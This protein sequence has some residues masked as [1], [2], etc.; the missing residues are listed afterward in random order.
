MKIIGSSKLVASMSFA[1]LMVASSA[2]IASAQNAKLDDVNGLWTATLDG[3]SV[4]GD[5][6]TESYP[7]AGITLRFQGKAVALT[8]NGNTL[9][10][11][12]GGGSTTGAVGV[13][14]GHNSASASA[15]TDV[16]LTMTGFATPDTTPEKDSM[17]GTWFGH[18][19]TLARDVS[20]K[21]PIDA[22]LPGD[23]PWVRYLRDVLIPLSAQD[24][25]STHKFDKTKGA[26]WLKSTELGAAD[27]WVHK[28]YFK[29]D[30]S[31]TAAINGMDGVLYTPRDI[32]ATKFNQI[33]QAN[34]S[35]AQKSSIALVLSSLSLYFSTACGG[36]VRIH[37]T[38][39]SDSVIYYITDRRATATIGLCLM[40]TPTQKPLA[41]SFGKWQNDCEAMTF[42]DDPNYIRAVLEIMTESSTKT[43]NKLSPEGRTSIADYLGIMAI[44]D[45]RGVMF[46]DDSQNWGQNMTHASF[47]IEIMRAL[48]HG[49]MRPAPQWDKATSKIVVGPQKEVA[50]QLIDGNNNLVPG[51]PSY[52]DTLN[53]GQNALAGGNKG[54]NDC[55]VDGL[56]PMETLTT[57]WLRSAHADVI[58][59]LEKDLAAFG[60]TTGSDNVF[61]NMINVLYDNAH[62]SKVT[63]AQASE[64]VDAGCALFQAI[65]SDSQKLEAFYLANGVKKGTDWAPRVAGF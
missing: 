31:Q 34:V 46:G 26:A 60:G 22:K 63:A 7:G 21:P 20:V 2:S 48:A 4:S 1:A 50:C 65:S 18:K 30:A 10:S 53:G 42:A 28:G 41:S 5:A 24:R 8:R 43:A 15:G 3:K 32:L 36:A 12:S 33:I 40:A 44:E 64:I 62:F 14:A 58:N 19:I 29:D 52:I 39:N 9:T 61:V 6:Q 13:I 38:D 17:A 59:R 55:Q 56:A 37:V 11:G 49:Q 23:R 16:Q 25:E 57:K 54:G 27:Y 51:T 47:D 35:P 45:Q